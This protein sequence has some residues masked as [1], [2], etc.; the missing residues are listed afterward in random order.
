MEKLPS[1][2]V[3]NGFPHLGSPGTMPGPHFYTGQEAEVFDNIHRWF[4]DE[5][6]SENIE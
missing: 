2:T 1:I 5:K 4:K 3:S 6:H